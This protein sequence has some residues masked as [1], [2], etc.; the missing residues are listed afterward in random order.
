MVLQQ[1]D[2]AKVGGGSG[3]LSLVDTPPP[4]SFLIY[5]PLGLAHPRGPHKHQQQPPGV[6]QDQVSV[7]LFVPDKSRRDL[8]GGGCAPNVAGANWIFT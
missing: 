7:A 4:H 6:H 8:T 1:A 2:G 3:S 5:F